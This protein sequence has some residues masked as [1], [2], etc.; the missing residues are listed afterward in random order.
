MRAEPDDL[1][2]IYNYACA[3]YLNEQYE[4]ANVQLAKIIS[5]DLQRDSEELE[6]MLK[7]VLE[8]MAQSESESEK[9][10]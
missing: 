1:L 10:A 6:K 5:E 8:K 4:E 2:V 9:A 3:L 7:P